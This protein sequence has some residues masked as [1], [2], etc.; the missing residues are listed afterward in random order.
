MT[1]RIRYK[2][3]LGTNCWFVFASFFVTYQGV[4]F[5]IWF[6][7]HVMVLVL[8]FRKPFSHRPLL[9]TLVSLLIRSSPLF[10]F[11]Q[12]LF[13]TSILSPPP[14]YSLVPSIDSYKD[15]SDLFHGHRNSTKANSEILTCLRKNGSVNR[16]E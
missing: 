13:F 7:V 10:Y 12:S 14:T 5:I 15:Y 11:S 16:K 1:K 9:L 2:K 3:A 4:R 8:C 6:M